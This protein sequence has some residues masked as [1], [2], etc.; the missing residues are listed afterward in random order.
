MFYDEL[1]G[2][3]NAMLFLDRLQQAVAHAARRQQ[4]VAL[5]Y[6]DVD[7]F[8]RIADRHDAI[9]GDRLMQEVASRLGSCIQRKEDTLARLC[10]DQFAMVLGDIDGID[11]LMKVIE[12]VSD[13][14]AARFRVGGRE[15]FITLS[16]GASVFPGDGK[17]WSSLLRSASIAMHQAKAA[18]GG[19]YC[20]YGEEPRKQKYGGEVI[21]KPQIP[22]PLLEQAKRRNWVP[23]SSMGWN[24][25][26]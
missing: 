2:L 10:G 7:G 15:H 4:I 26:P 11:G 21:S 13:E 8:K 17:D 24:V 1:T 12:R 3:P 23:S 19:R 9:D 25:T 18:G 20:C 5:L 14:M 16:L 22:L 6:M